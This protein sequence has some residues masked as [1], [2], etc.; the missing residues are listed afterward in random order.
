[1]YFHLQD[2]SQDDMEGAQVLGAFNGTLLRF[3]KKFRKG[4]SGDVVKDED[5]DFMGAK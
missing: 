2:K 5:F 1:M 3:K 4:L